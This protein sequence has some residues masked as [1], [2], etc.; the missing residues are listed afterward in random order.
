MG[1]PAMSTL[2]REL[3]AFVKGEG[4]PI[5]AA[6]KKRL[7]NL[8][9]TFER[10]AGDQSNEMV[11]QLF[12]SDNQDL[13]AILRTT[14]T[15]LQEDASAASVGALID[16]LCTFAENNQLSGADATG[17]A[18]FAGSQADLSGGEAI[19]D[20][21]HITLTT[22]VAQGLRQAFVRAMED[23]PFDE[24]QRKRLEY[25]IE[26]TS[27]VEQLMSLYFTRYTLGRPADQ[28]AFLYIVWMLWAFLRVKT[29]NP[30][31]AVDSIYQQL[32]RL[33]GD[34]ITFNYTN[35]FDRN[36]RRR[37]LFFHGQLGEYIQLDDREI[38]TDSAELRAASTVAG[39]VD[40]IKTVRLDDLAGGALDVPALVPPTKFKPVMSRRQLQTWAR[41]D[42]LIS[43][44]TSVVVIGYSFALADEHFNDLLRHANPRVPVVVVNPDIVTASREASRVLGIDAASLVDEERGNF[45]T[46]RS[47]R[48]VCVAARA[49][50]VS[51]ELLQLLR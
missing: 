33:A 37:V 30:P 51:E 17:V 1:V 28:K 50:D 48:L 8:R 11:R 5:H 3:A 42:A 36:T 6:L 15:R 14:A 31:V 35:F 13:V 7:P 26:A 34:V 20:P 22:P 9:F 38:I 21:E 29:Y 49:E 43:A 16:R 12:S 45:D 19:L 10:Y 39:I 2:L 40:L 47:G 27:N 46:K 23:D 18:R 41:A 4:Q 24:N 25:F 32:P 44:A